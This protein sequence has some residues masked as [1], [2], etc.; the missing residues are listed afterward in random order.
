ME[1]LIESC[2]SGIHLDFVFSKIVLNS[3]SRFLSWKA[4]ISNPVE[5]EKSESRAV[6]CLHVST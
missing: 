4:S 6:R 5:R 1:A 2:T 3:V